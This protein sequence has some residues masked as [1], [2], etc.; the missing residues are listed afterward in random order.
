MSYNDFSD[1][2]AEEVAM[3][4]TMS[5]KFALILFCRPS[6]LLF[7]LCIVASIESIEQDNWK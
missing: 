6:A 5:A 2:K 4:V 3:T 1:L 7:V